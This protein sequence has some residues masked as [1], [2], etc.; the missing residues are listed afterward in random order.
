MTEIATLPNFAP[1][2]VEMLLAVGAM[3]LLMFGVFTGENSAPTIT[4]IAVAL[5]GA[6]VLMLAV[7]DNNGT[8]FDGAFILDPFARFMKIPVS[9]THLTLPTN[10]EM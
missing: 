2:A 5:L 7:M 1:L 4:G 3:A 10:R 6:G 9:Y 8:T